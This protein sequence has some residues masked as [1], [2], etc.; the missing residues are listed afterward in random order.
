MLLWRRFNI[1]TS[2]QRPYNVLRTSCVGWKPIQ[3]HNIRTANII[4]QPFSLLHIVGNILHFSLFPTLSLLTLIRFLSPKNACSHQITSSSP[5]NSTMSMSRSF[6]KILNV[7]LFPTQPTHDVRT[8]SYGRWNDVKTLK[9]RRYNVVL[10]SVAND[11]LFMIRLIQIGI[12]VAKIKYMPISHWYV[13]LKNFF[14]FFDVYAFYFVLSCTMTSCIR[15]AKDA[16]SFC[17]KGF[18]IQC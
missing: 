7:I 1:L 5:S 15:N 14:F 6:A 9:R 10:T 3:H 13:S 12:F 16:G 17:S 11:F 2:F 8:T 4:H 18:L